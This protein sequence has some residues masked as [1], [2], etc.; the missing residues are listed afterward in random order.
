M[1]RKTLRFTFRDK[2][3]PSSH[4]LRKGRCGDYFIIQGMRNLFPELANVTFTVKEK[5]VVWVCRLVKTWSTAV[6]W[7]G[8]LTLKHRMLNSKM[9]VLIRV[10]VTKIIREKLIHGE[11][12]TL[13]VSRTGATKI[14]WQRGTNAAF[15]LDE[16]LLKT[17]HEVTNSSVA[18]SSFLQCGTKL[19]QQKC[20]IWKNFSGSGS[21]PSV[22]V[23]SS[24]SFIFLY[25][26]SSMCK[27]ELHGEWS[28]RGRH[29]QN[30]DECAN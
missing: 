28:T 16:E 2:I 17:E 27:A 30:H 4:V 1:E 21:A 6:H 19:S 13:F 26:A 14:S 20:T 18:F 15:C 24:R 25:T 8:V 23:E 11:L 9:T 22:A 12:A 3:L 5:P 10:S 7:C 29:Q